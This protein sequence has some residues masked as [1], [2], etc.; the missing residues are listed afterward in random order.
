MARARGTRGRAVVAVVRAIVAVVSATAARANEEFVACRDAREQA[1]IDV[2]ATAAMGAM[3]SETWKRA[4]VNDVR[5]MVLVNVH[6]HVPAEHRSEGEYSTREVSETGFSCDEDATPRTDG[7]ASSDAFAHCENVALGDTVELHWVY[8]TGGERGAEISDGLG[9]AFATQ[10]NPLIVVRAQVFRVTNGGD[11]AYDDDAKSLLSGW[12]ASI[13][14]DALQ[15]IGSTTGS[16][17]DSIDKCSPYAVTWHVDRKCHDISARKIDEM[18]GEMKR[19]YSMTEDIRAHESRE[20]VPSRLM[21][22]ET[23]PLESPFF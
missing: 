7:E 15:Y 2:S 12:N 9:S 6:F 23:R 22:S 18:C 11:G 3:A 13:V 20:L 4:M 19:T 21:T 16:K 17:Y 14:T 1:P 10:R 5:G 8:S